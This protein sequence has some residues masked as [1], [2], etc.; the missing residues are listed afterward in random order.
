MKG[1]VFNGQNFVYMYD[2]AM[3]AL[4][5]DDV[6]MSDMIPVFS[7]HE[8]TG[9]ALSFPEMNEA[10]SYEILH[11]TDNRY[12]FEYRLEKYEKLQRGKRLRT[13]FTGNLRDLL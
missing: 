7:Q 11:N 10:V 1:L 12:E 4:I 13:G 5:R 2:N 3:D 6:V 8:G 9:T